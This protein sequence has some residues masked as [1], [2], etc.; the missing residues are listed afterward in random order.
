M[1]IYQL[2]QRK[3]ATGRPRRIGVIGAG[4][5]ST[6]FLAQVRLTPGIQL[7]GI[8]ELKPEKSRQACLRVGFPEDSLS[9]ASSAAAIND[10]ARR[11]K[12]TLTD[13]PDQLIQADLDIILE[14]TG[15]PEAGTYHAWQALEADKHV[16]MVNVEADALLG[17]VLK[18]KADEKGLVYSLAYGD[19]PALICELVDWARAIGVEV[20]CAGKGTRYQPEYHYSTPKT[21]WKYYGFSEEQLQSGDYNAQMFNSFLDGTKS[22]I[23]MCAVANASGLSPQRCG[24]KFPP[25][26]VDAL[27]DT[28]KPESAGGILEH[29]GTVEVI[30][31]ETR[32][33]T[34]VEGGLRWGVYV[35][36][37]APSDYVKRCFLEYGLATDSSGQYAALYRPYHLIGLELGISVASV[38]LRGE[39]TGSP[40][41][42]LADVA[43]VAKKELKAGDILDGEGGYTVYGRLARAE[44][45]LAAGYL[46][47]GLSSQARVIRPVAKGTVLSYDDVAIDDRLFSYKIRK[48][49]EKDN[50]Y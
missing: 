23:E 13:D 5:F 28:L 49:M 38:G 35:V 3:A 44:D 42:F 33:G 36:F 32:D 10:G 45:S 39:P 31:S 21:V 17:P 9:F 8:A 40:Q 14:I 37:K 2:L 11:G 41:S 26:G 19:Q 50:P 27:A 29:S 15:V 48:I 34:P 46:P 12:T 18:K 24:L 20:V 43:S 1:N 25:V 47:I 16:I 30:A 4:K 6:M 22:A 7:V